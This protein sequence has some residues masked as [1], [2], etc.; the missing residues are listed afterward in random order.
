MKGAEVV[1]EVNIKDSKYAIRL[2]LPTAEGM[3]EVGLRC[4]DVRLEYLVWS[5]HILTGSR[6]L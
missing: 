6:L 2:M 4:E 5:R 1:P 3:N